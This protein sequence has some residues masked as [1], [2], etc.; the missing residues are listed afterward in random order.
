MD[1]EKTVREGFEVHRKFLMEEVFSDEVLVA[2][3]QVMDYDLAKNLRPDTAEA[4]EF[5]PEYMNEMR[6]AAVDAI[7]ENLMEQVDD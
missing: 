1:Y 3:I 5:I 7:L 2:I 4:P 6:T